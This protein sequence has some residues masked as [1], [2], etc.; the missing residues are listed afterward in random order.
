M[1][2]DSDS[3]QQAL[4]AKLT[5]WGQQHLVGFWDQ[6]N[7]AQR[8]SLAEQIESIDFGLLDRVFHAHDDHTAVRRLADHAQSPPAVRLHSQHNP[9]SAADARRAGGEL[10]S[11]GQVGVLLVAGGQGTRLGFD[12]PKGMFP[13]G[14]LSKRPLFQIFVEKMLAVGRRYGAPLPLYLMTSHA[15]HQETVDF[16]RAQGRFGLAEQDLF[17]FRQGTMPAADAQSGRLLLEAPDRLF[18]SPDG[19]GGMLA[20]LARSGGL[21]D[22]R[23]RG[24][25]H[26]FYFQ[27]DNPLVDLAG[28]EF[29]GY[30]RLSGSE[31][32]TQVVAK[33]EPLEKVGNVVLADGAVRV[34]EYSDLPDDVARRRAAD[35]SL[36]I[37][38]GS[39]GV[40]AID[41][42]FLERMAA[43]DDA[44]PL[45]RARKKV[46]YLDASGQLVKPQEPNAIKFERF[47]FD[48]LPAA[49][50][51]IVVEVDPAEAFAPLK[52][53]LN[54]PKDNAHTVQAQMIAQHQRWLQ[55]AGIEVAN[56]ARVEISPLFAPD[57]DALREKLTPGTKITQDQYFS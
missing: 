4:L 45:H 52:N 32:T 24:V 43:R 29:L 6:L 19:H 18:A 25:R 22:M 46:P 55:Q 53:G 47:I 20:A 44:L 7:V 9:I 54:D 13:I 1:T 33:Q 40:H 35:G 51:A 48:L 42:A 11:A 5:P 23:R 26:L 17:I 30:H 16:F 21:A 28:A 34:I 38:A 49:R 15:T 36:A 12:H 8:T 31:M 37:W 27:V 50:N 57:P 14:P 41:V 39:I 10:L 3:Q 56:D 2:R